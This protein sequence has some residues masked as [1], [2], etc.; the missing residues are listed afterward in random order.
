MTI[1]GARRRRL[2]LC[3]RHLARI[4]I[5]GSCALL[6]ASPALRPLLFARAE[7]LSD[8][9]SIFLSSANV[10]KTKKRFADSTG[11]ASTDTR[12]TSSPKS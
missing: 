9:T 12:S 10:K 6:A 11:E 1:S 4:S 8:G 7:D 5:G 3:Q 2:L